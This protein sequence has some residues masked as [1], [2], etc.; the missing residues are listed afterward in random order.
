[1]LDSVTKGSTAPDPLVNA[2]YRWRAERRIAE[3]L[4]VAVDPNMEVG[5]PDEAMLEAFYKDH[6]ERFTAP[7]YPKIS[8]V[9]I[10]QAELAADIGIPAETLRQDHAS[11]IDEL[12]VLT[13]QAVC[14]IRS[15]R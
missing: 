13:P 11:R 4:P 2:L 8:Y 1:M 10:R 12:F 7:R 3:I 5:K 9:H 14:E 6:E 15:P